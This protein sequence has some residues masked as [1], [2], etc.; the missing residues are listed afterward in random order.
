LFLKK[1]Y[2]PNHRQN[3][4]KHEGDV[5]GARERYYRNPSNNLRFLLQ[6]RYV[7]MNDYLCPESRGLEVGSG[8]GIGRDWIRCRQ[9]YLSD[10][11]GYPW[12]DFKQVDA[13]HTPFEPQ[14]FDFVI[15][16]NMIHHLAYPARF[17]REMNR[18]LRPEGF[19]LIQ[20]IHASFLMRLILRLMRHEG[21]D[22]GVPVFGEQT[23]CNNPGDL[24]SANCAIPDLLFDRHRVFEDKMPYFKILRH[25]YGEFIIFLN[26]GGVIAK[27]VFV[28]LPRLLLK[29]AAC[30]DEGLCRIFPHLFALQQ[31][32]VLQKRIP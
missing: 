31:R 16:N 21:Y 22:Y 3:R 5:P 26:S 10:L 25:E 32:V 23:P 4:M 17:F 30:T 27:T 7:W 9:F 6:K 13:M 2:R 15:A 1:S 14:S 29:A 11:A 24:W 12:L 8:A 28:P 20:E 19:L 18:I